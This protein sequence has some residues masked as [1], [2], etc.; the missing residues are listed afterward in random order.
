MV[1]K[2]K[3]ESTEEQILDAAQEVFLKKGN[4]G[5][6]MQEIADKAGIN[7]ALLHYYYRSKQKL[8]EAVFKMAFK[9]FFPKIQT[10][11]TSEKPLLEKLD[12]FVDMYMSILQKNPYIPAFV[13]HE[14]NRNS[15]SV[16]NLFGELLTDN[17]FKSEG[18]I[19]L[20]SK[21]IEEEVKAG[22]IRMVDPRQL[23]V[24]IISLCVFPFVA[25]PIITGI[26]LGGE[27][28]K[29]KIFIEE[30]KS[31]VKEFIKNA[32]SIK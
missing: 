10:H 20:L 17:K 14:I 4:D 21:Q 1:K 29:Y 19:E 30:R 25:K 6:R 27:K 12:A 26:I 32:I 3:T 28:D 16:T 9:N 8:F 11:F 23:M 24:S 5:T 31:F 22:K 15:D 18:M 13:I 7:K 2:I